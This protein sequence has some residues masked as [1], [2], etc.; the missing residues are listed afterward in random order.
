MARG[1]D[2]EVGGQQVQQF[3]SLCQQYEVA[4]AA[5]VTAGTFSDDAEKVSQGS[6]VELLDA[7]GIA[8]ILKRKEWIDLAEEY[9]GGDVPSGGDGDS[10]LDSLKAVSERASSLVSGALGDTDVSVP[11]KPALGVVVVVALLAVGVLVGPSIPFLGGGGG[12]APISAESV[13]PANSTTNVTVSWNAKVVDTIDPNESDGRAYH[14]PRGEQFVLVRMSVNNTG[15][16]SAKVRQAGFKLR[17]ENR[18]YSH[19]PLNE[20]DGFVDFAISPGTNYVGWT[21]FSVP[22]GTTGTLVYER[23]ASDKPIAVSFDHDPNLAVNVTQR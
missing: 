14:A 3:A 4:E 6:G 16:K 7:E 22:K 20:H 23:N 18:T 11:T 21:V 19:Q 2:G 13:A 10:P 8:Q 1:D 5:I 17:T 9:G 12:G 15:E